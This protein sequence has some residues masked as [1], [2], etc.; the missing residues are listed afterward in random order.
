[1][2]REINLRLLKEN[3]ELFFKK[4]SNFKRPLKT[5]VIYA[6]LTKGFVP[7][8]E[9]NGHRRRIPWKVLK[10]DQTVNKFPSAFFTTKTGLHQSLQQ[11]HWY[12]PF[13]VSSFFPRCYQVSVSF[14][15]PPPPRIACGTIGQ[16]RV[17]DWLFISVNQWR[18][19]VR[20]CWWLSHY[21]LHQ[22][23]SVVLHG[24]QKVWRFR[25]GKFRCQSSP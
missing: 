25:C 20:I 11:L 14:D 7:H 22:Y 3:I 6:K 2:Y 5:D 19:K 4:E 8:Y 1:M 12:S 13:P 15:Q 24:I 18:R 10:K 21:C 9:W 17:I 16:G 23:P